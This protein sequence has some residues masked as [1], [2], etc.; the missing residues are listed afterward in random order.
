M[1]RPEAQIWGGKT[2]FSHPDYNVI[3]FHSP[4][5]YVCVFVCVCV[6][7]C[8]SV[9]MSI[10]VSVYMCVCVRRQG[11]IRYIFRL[12]VAGMLPFGKTCKALQATSKDRIFRSGRDG[13]RINS[14]MLGGPINLWQTKFSY[15]V[16]TG[17]ICN[18]HRWGGE[19]R[20]E[21]WVERRSSNKKREDGEEKGKRSRRVMFLNILC[22]VW[23]SL[24]VLQGD[25]TEEKNKP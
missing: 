15:T 23:Y 12:C 5:V 17:S 6:W 4:R 24:H 8:S 2:Y 9:P 25:E 22:T 21:M 7:L 16:H 3:L 1:E 10:C 18:R 19:D 20:K 11:L 13:G 14:W